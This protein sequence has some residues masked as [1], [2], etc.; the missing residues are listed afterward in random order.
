[1]PLV[2]LLI[3]ILFWVTVAT[4]TAI[5]SMFGAIVHIFSRHGA[6]LPNAPAPRH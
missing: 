3:G 6:D 5:A 1:M 4:L 2:F